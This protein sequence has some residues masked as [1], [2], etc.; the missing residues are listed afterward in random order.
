MIVVVALAPLLAACTGDGGEALPSR[1]ATPSRTLSATGPSVSLPSRSEDSASETGEPSPEQSVEQSEAAPSVEVS[2]ERSASVD[3]QQSAEVVV[4]ATADSTTEA[5]SSES[6]GTSA[7]P[8]WALVALVILGVAIA[9]WQHRQSRRRDARESFELALSESRWLGRDLLPTLLASSRDERRGA[10]SVARPRV[11]ALE[12]RLAALGAPGSE[13]TGAVKAQRLEMAVI[14]V[15]GALDNESRSDAGAA[16]EAFG[17]V[18]QAAR[19]L[20][21]ALADALP[22]P[23]PG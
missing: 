3:V 14:G 16:A 13:T 15:R 22:T 10:W 7:W 18:K 2:T 8:L 4:S 17:G 1:T 21:Q 19:Q 12:D 9:L 23:T 20:D 11:V 5:D 6:D